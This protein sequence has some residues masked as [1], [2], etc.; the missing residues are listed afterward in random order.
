M[1]PLAFRH[2]TLRNT[3][4][5]VPDTRTTHY[6]GTCNLIHIST[7]KKK[8]RAFLALDVTLYKEEKTP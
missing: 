1:F 5:L 4:S 3:L 2:G 7:G 6:S 8:P